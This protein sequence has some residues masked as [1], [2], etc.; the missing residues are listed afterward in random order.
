[1]PL[2]LQ[3]SEQ[4]LED[5]KGWAALAGAAGGALAMVLVVSRVLVRLERQS[6]ADLRLDRTH[7]RALIEQGRLDL[8]EAE[9]KIDAMEAEV[10]ECQRER[11]VDRGKIAR[12]EAEVA[13]LKLNLR[14][15]GEATP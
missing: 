9:R 8:A 4:V 14:A 12:L 2:L 7:D 3:G 1:M 11:A 5:A 13:T 10:E 15:A 6:I